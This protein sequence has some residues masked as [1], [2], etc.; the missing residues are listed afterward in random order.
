[1]PTARA[2]HLTAGLHH[3][4]EA[5]AEFWADL[6]EEHGVSITTHEDLDAGCA[7]LAAHRHEL[8][9]VSALRWSM[10]NHE[11]YAIYREQWGYDIPPAARDAISA[12][13]KRGGALLALHAAAI[14]FDT[15]PQWEDILG[16]R[17]VWGQSSHPPYGPVQTRV[18][19]PAHPLMQGV[20]AF[21]SR[22]E[23]YGQLRRASHCTVLAESCAE[24]QDWTPTVWCQMWQGARVYYDALGHNTASFSDPAHRRLLSNALAWLLDRTSSQASE[25]T[26]DA[27]H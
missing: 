18:V 3:P 21:Q 20:N 24:D 22:D 8:L 4:A 19:A 14:S 2:I 15:W 9:V 5:T 11:K 1:M 25:N 26:N 12:H 10:T 27:K 17:W 16:G 6:F 23:V 13:L 7:A